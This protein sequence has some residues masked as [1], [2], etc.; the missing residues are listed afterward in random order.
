MVGGLSERQ[1]CTLSGMRRKSY[2]YR[3]VR[4]RD[5]SLAGRIRELAMKYPRYGY[6]RVW[7]MLVRAGELI[8]RKR[9]YRLWRELK[10]ALPKRRPRRPRAKPFIGIMPKAEK[11][12]QIWTYDFV[13]DESVSG[14]KLKMLTL[15]DEYTRECLA[16]EVDT[17]I[18]SPKVRQILEKV[19]LIR[20]FPSAI[21]SD[22]GSEFIGSAVN[23]WLQMNGINPIFIEPGKPWQNGKCESFNGK[24][25][26]EC[27]SRRW[28]GS[29][30]EARVVIESWRNFY[31]TERPH[32]ALG[33]LTPAEFGRKASLSTEL[34]SKPE[35]FLTKT[36]AF[37]L[38]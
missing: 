15:I 8:N 21:R 6:R 26:D 32:S 4:V 14:R 19:C 33:Y 36:L 28:F 27:L 23:G 10:L 20:G 13:F 3:V 37:Q 22:N 16:V 25:R 30:W 1:A 2:R 29:L 34:K 35:P 24:L 11:M 5:S 7:A 9:V 17:S 38:G 12:N 18:T 31:N